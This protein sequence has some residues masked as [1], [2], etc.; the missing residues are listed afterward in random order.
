MLAS[1]FN[2]LTDSSITSAL[3]GAMIYT[4]SQRSFSGKGRVIAF[5]V[6]FIMGG[7]GAEMTADI[8]SEYLP[9]G[10]SG[11]KNIGAFVCSALVVTVSVKIIS[12]VDDLVLKKKD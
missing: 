7:V 11:N 4:L 1:I 10:I 12:Y 2:R 9:Q 5:I 3:A 6:S 8:L